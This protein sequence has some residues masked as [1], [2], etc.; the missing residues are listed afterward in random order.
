ML[1]FLLDNDNTQTGFAGEAVGK[2]GEAV[3]PK[4]RRNRAAKNVALA[5]LGFVI[6]EPTGDDLEPA[7]A[8]SD[9]VQLA[10]AARAA[11]QEPR[12]AARRAAITANATVGA[13]KA[14]KVRK[15]RRTAALCS[16]RTPAPVPAAVPQPEPERQR[17]AQR[18]SAA[19]DSRR[20]A[21][22][23]ASSTATRTRSTTAAAGG[24]G[25]GGL[26]AVRERTADVGQIVDVGGGGD[27]MLLSVIDQLAQRSVSIV[28][29]FDQSP[30]DNRSLT[31]EKLRRWLHQWLAHYRHSF[32]E[33]INSREAGQ[34]A[35]DEH[36]SWQHFLELTG[37]PHAYLQHLHLTALAT[38]LNATIHV[39]DTAGVSYDTVIAPLPISAIDIT[40]AEQ[41][42]ACLCPPSERT[43]QSRT[44][45]R[46]L[47]VVYL[48]DPNSNFAHYQSIRPPAPASRDVQ[49][50]FVE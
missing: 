49:R 9:N 3:Q 43:E 7:A 39:Y 35:L 32:E 28:H 22:T 27:C 37:T 21:S 25:S 18:A 20:S 31:F 1:K 36:R 38:M 11:E 6:E 4:R 12:R 24:S 16:R 50:E 2:S 47:F 29:P 17:A 33:F 30:V 13:K 23:A 26:A 46:S 14:S 45:S 40:D 8:P 5:K 44:Q 15:R 34:R 48:F 41:V 42:V 19:V 10:A